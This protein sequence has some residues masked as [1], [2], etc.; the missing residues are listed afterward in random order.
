MYDESD[1]GYGFQDTTG[2]GWGNRDSQTN[3]SVLQDVGNAKTYISGLPSGVTFR[4]TFFPVQPGGT[5]PELTPMIGYNGVFALGTSVGVTSIVPNQTITA[6]AYNQTTQTLYPE[7]NSV[8]PLIRPFPTTSVNFTNG[9]YPGTL[10]DG[11]Q[12]S[13][14]YNA[15]RQS[16]L[17]HNFIL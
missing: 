3:P 11:A 6:A 14:Y 5:V 17:N 15:V 12:A 7:Y 16:L 1:S 2:N 8:P 4:A 9:G 13:D 10:P